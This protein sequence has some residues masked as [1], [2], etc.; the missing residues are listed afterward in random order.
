MLIERAV[1]KQALSQK[2]YR[3]LDYTL[4]LDDLSRI[5]ALRFT[6]AGGGPFLADG[7]ANIPSII[8]MG[9]W[10]RAVDAVH[11]DT[12]TAADLRYLLGHGSPL[13][14]ARP[15]SAVVLADGSLAIAKFPKADDIRDI[16]AGEVLAL[17]LAEKAGLTVA[18]AELTQVEGRSVSI[19]KRF[20][21]VG[22][23]RVPFLSASSLLGTKAGEAGTYTM[24]ADAIRSFGDDVKTDLRELWRRMV[25]ALLI[26]SYDDHL[27]NHGFLMRNAGRWALSPAYDLNPVPEIDRT[28]A[29]ETAISEE[30]SE[31]S[32]AEALRVCARFGLKTAEAKGV[33][34]EVYEAVI[35]WNEV[36][37]SLGLGGRIM[38]SYASAFR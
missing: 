2:P 33:L 13:G 24:I 29:P 30:L 7:Q 23:H 12:E 21:R 1:R 27:R 22:N 26:S 16:C 25:Y 4:A 35:S 15:K 19:I 28:Q 34:R 11:S 31:L 10:L 17:R 14:G 18:L 6:E 36:G 5:G 9:A 32:L 3:D 20:D 38:E 8:Q 37:R